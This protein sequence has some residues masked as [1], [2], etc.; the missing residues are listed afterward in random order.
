MES[1]DV[2]IATLKNKVHKK[3]DGGPTRIQDQGF[4]WTS[5]LEAY[6]N[7]G[8]MHLTNTGYVV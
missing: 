1:K 8:C 4:P 7:K 6:K 5:A 2:A 3:E